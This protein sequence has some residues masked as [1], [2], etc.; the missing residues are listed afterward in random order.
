MV[1]Y[2]LA[3]MVQRSQAYGLLALAAQAYWGLSPLPEMARGPQGKPFFPDLPQYHFNVSHSGTLALCAVGDEPVGVDLQ[4][5]RPRRE[6]F[7]DRLLSPEERIWLRER[8]DS[9]EA[10]TQLWTLK[11]SVCKYSGR[12]L[13]QPISDIRVPLPQCRPGA[14]AVLQENGLFF[15]LYSGPQWRACVCSRQLPDGDIRWT[16][17]AQLP[18]VQRPPHGAPRR[19]G[20]G[21]N[22]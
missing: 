22:L 1:L 8:W 20:Q 15:T 17:A 7:L 21:S 11:E 2:G 5:V 10:F 18:H 19:E 13:T 6:K 16:G 3:D 14:P 4:V 9:P 12:G